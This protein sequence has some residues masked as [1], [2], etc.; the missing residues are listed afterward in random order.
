MRHILTLILFLIT[1]FFASSCRQPSHIV[2]M[3]DNGAWCWFQDPRAVYINNQHERTYANWV[4]NEGELQVGAFDH[5]SGKIVLF[6]MKENWDAD[7]HNTGAFLVLHDNRLMLFYAKHCKQGLYC[8]KTLYPEDITQWEDEVVVSDGMDITYAHPIYLTEEQRYYVFWR[9]PS[10]K[11]TFST[12]EDGKIWTKPKILIQ[13]KGRE[14]HDIRPYT[15]IC[16]DGV[17]GIHCAFTD[18]H[19]RKEPENSLYYLNYEKG[20]LLRADG[21]WLGS[22]NNLPIQHSKSDLV[23]NG[24]VE[25]G[26]AWVWDIAVDQDDH[27]VIA[28]TRLPS[29][30]DHRYC[31]ARWTGNQWLDVEITKGGGWF[32]QTPEGHTEPEPHY[33]GGMALDPENPSI[34]YV[35]QPI[36]GVFEIIK[37]ETQDGGHSWK[38]DPITHNSQVNQVRPVVPRGYKGS[39][40]TLL[41]WMS[42]KY[43]HY[44]N[45]DTGIRLI[46]E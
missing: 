17:L 39:S 46:C 22:S 32:P 41:L 15:K 38:S 28:Y 14:G 43:E 44:T 6:T 42:G 21:T 25:K 7:D 5:Q 12:S 24:N 16:S 3:T 10:W 2:G 31:Y 27:P 30:T 29:E 45:F 23:Y 1:S 33:S 40:K 34:V 36:N 4:T 37:W 35:S 20:Q 13:E 26:R 9:G 11:P 8:R 19:P 18:G